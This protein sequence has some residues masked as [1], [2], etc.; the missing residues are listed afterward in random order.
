MNIYFGIDGTTNNDNAS[1]TS[2]TEPLQVTSFVKRISLM[3]FDRASYIAGPMD[4]YTSNDSVQLADR[5]VQWVL[6]ARNATAKSDNLRIFLGGF[7]RGCASV[8]LAC[9]KLNASKIP[10]HGL[11]LFDAVDRTFA[12]NSKTSRTIPANVRKAFHAYRDPNANSRPEFGNCGMVGLNNNLTKRPFYCTHGGMGGWRL[13]SER[14]VA[15]NDFASN[16]GTLGMLNLRMTTKPNNFSS[17]HYTES[18]SP[19]IS[20]NVTAIQQLS[21]SLAVWNWMQANVLTSRGWNLAP[22]KSG[23]AYA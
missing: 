2:A 7:S 22:S 12:I 17:S 21:G 9:E 15:P 3:N 16:M 11:F 10:V 8:M 23:Q 19:N 1:D 20:T 18:W 14:L 5:A 6:A 4:K 13:G